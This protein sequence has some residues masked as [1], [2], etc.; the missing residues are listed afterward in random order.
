M[1]HEG[2]T[3]FAVNIFPDDRRSLRERGQLARAVQ[4]ALRGA[5]V[6]PLPRVGVQLK[7]EQLDELTGIV[8]PIAREVIAT[9]GH[10]DLFADEPDAIRGMVH[11]QGVALYIPPKASGELQNTAGIEQA[12]MAALRKKDPD[13]VPLIDL[14]STRLML[15][16]E[17]GHDYIR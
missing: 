17:F 13:L 11:D 4:Q 3:V 14:Q 8:E 1:D 5:T 9:G 6:G 12:L 10:T 16:D 15:R 2:Q 7:P